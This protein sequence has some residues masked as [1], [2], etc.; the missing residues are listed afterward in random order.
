MDSLFYFPINLF[1]LFI[2]SYSFGH[3]QQ[4]REYLWQQA[5]KMTLF[6]AFSTK[7]LKLCSIC[8]RKNFF[9]ILKF[10]IIKNKVIIKVNQN[11]QGGINSNQ[12]KNATIWRNLIVI[13]ALMMSRQRL[14][15]ELWQWKR[16]RHTQLEYLACINNCLLARRVLGICY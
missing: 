15:G 10:F 4:T 13:F 14:D 9:F 16:S 2:A 8:Q 7:L 3:Q 5:I 12:N 11:Y 1:M 6:H